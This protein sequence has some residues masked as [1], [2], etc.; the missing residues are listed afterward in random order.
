MKKSNLTTVKD[1]EF[2]LTE[3]TTEFPGGTLRPFGLKFCVVVMRF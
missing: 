1:A 3:Q 2:L